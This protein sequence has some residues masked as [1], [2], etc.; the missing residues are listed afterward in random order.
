MKTAWI[1][2]SYSYNP[3]FLWIF[4]TCSSLFF[5]WR[6]SLTTSC[7]AWWQLCQLVNVQ[8]HLWYISQWVLFSGFTNVFLVGIILLRS[9]SFPPLTNPQHCRDE[10]SL[11]KR[12]LSLG[13]S[14]SQL[15]LGYLTLPCCC[16]RGRLTS[17][18]LGFLLKLF[19]SIVLVK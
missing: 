15:I 5:G 17:F 9:L 6:T 12:C 4:A 14:G 19:K 7:K 8:Q 13:L 18:N 11:W 16:Q 1:L 10:K 3:S 2:A